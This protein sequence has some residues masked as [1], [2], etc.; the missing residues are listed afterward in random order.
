MK[1]AWKVDVAIYSGEL[2]SGDIGGALRI[3][4]V[5]FRVLDPYHTK[6]LDAT[7]ETTKNGYDDPLRAGLDRFGDILRPRLRAMVTGV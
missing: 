6:V 7:G 4:A 5:F 1:P 2:T 3:K